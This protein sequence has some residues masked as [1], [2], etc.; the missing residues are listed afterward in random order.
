MKQQRHNNEILIIS[1]YPPRACGIATF[2]KDLLTALHN[3]FGHMLHFKVC[4]L[5]DGLN[6][7]YG[8][9]VLLT[10]NTGDNKEYERAAAFINKRN[11]IKTVI[12]EHEFGLFGGNFGQDVLKNADTH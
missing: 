7:E 8:D 6:Y 5:E 11:S 3:T 4:A 1:S 9:D 10:I 12:L 2:S